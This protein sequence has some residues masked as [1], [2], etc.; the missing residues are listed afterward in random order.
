MLIDN[1]YSIL[2]LQS[3]D[4]SLQAIIDIDK[5]HPIF[6]GHF[7]ET[8]VVPGVC[9]LQIVKE[10]VE[11]AEN[12]KFRMTHG[13]NI[14]FLSVINPD[15]NNRVKVEIQFSSTAGVYSVQAIFYTEMVACFKFKGSF[16]AL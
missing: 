8:P 1:F 5:N 13:D 15:Q 11:K 2:E 9:M 7:P 3:D 14:K 10:L 6:K 12:K 4:A 16:Q